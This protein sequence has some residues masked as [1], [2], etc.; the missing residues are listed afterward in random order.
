MDLRPTWRGLVLRSIS[1]ALL[2]TVRPN[3]A[4]PALDVLFQVEHDIRN[5][6]KASRDGDSPSNRYEALSLWPAACELHK[7]LISHGFPE[8]KPEKYVK[9]MDVYASIAQSEDCN[10]S[11]T[12]ACQ[13]LHIPR[14][15]DPNPALV[16]LR[17]QFPRQLITM[18]LEDVPFLREVGKVHLYGT[19]SALSNLSNLL[20]DRGQDDDT[21]W[22]EQLRARLYT[23]AEE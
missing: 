5:P 17:Q 16:Y 23:P 20:R 15:P 12:H 10:R 1:Q 7:S 19:I 8:T 9:F 14:A 18:R 13:A 2:Q 3:S 22:M 21:Q 4:D 11:W 6:T